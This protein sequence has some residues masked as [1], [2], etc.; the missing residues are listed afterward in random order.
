[1]RRELRILSLF[2][3]II[4]GLIV[5][6]AALTL[7]AGMEERIIPGVWLW[8]TSMG[9]AKLVDGNLGTAASV[10]EA[11]A[12]EQPRIVL[13]GPEEQRWAFSPVDL[14]VSVAFK[15][16][17]SKVY[18]VGHTQSEAKM[19]HLIPDV[20][21]DR[22]RVM[23]EGEIVAPVL[24][25]DRDQ[26][27]G[28]L[29]A[30]AAQL[31]YPP[32]DARLR[33][34]N[35][36]LLLDAGAP[37]RRLEITSTL[38][39]L[40]PLLQSP[41]SAVAPTELRLVVNGL[42]PRITDE[43]V[44]RAMDIARTIVSQELLL[45]L[46]DPEPGDPGPWSLARDV[47]ANMLVIQTSEANVSVGLDEEALRQFL[48][49]IAMALYREPVSSRFHF[50]EAT[51]ELEP[52]VSSVDGRALD[53]DATI[54]YVNDVL[55]VGQHVVPLSLTITPP[56]YPDTSTAQ[57]LDIQELVAM[58]ESYF[59]GSS[60]ARDKNIRL[61]ASQFDGLIIASGQTFSFNEYLGDVTPEKGYDESYVIIGN[62][63]VPGVGGG[64]CQ[65]ATTVFR[66]AFNGGYE[67][68]ER[69][70]HAYRVGYYEL[71][72]FGPG[73]DATVYSPLVDFRFVND[74]P[75]PLL[76]Q[77]E[78][79]TAHARLRFLFYSTDDGRTV[80]QIGPTW[81]DPIPPE[82]PVYEYDPTMPVGTVERLE[83]A[84]DGLTAVLERVVRDAEGHILHQDRFVSNFVPW[85][86]R[87][88]YGPEFIPPT[89]A[90]VLTPEVTPTPSTP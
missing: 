2:M 9:G 63:T 40:Y 14:G 35:H 45:I 34:G 62:R 84:H 44:A 31:D 78:V 13:V 16:T 28:K 33:M 23:L 59:S 77:T 65:V 55:Q 58:G 57:A 85:S 42:P 41:T 43:E 17:M 56:A 47:V 88:R 72:G 22:L 54:E 38:E 1:M 26:A 90:V 79:D 48:D 52:L 39:A 68:V 53:M 36:Q 5:G 89:D 24:V 67:I 64:I 12:L 81:G 70:P 20:L 49:P 83:R 69:W 71:G 76:I 60:S 8:H 27:I 66:A 19:R 46:P 37:G 29:R 51:L 87:Y 6:G 50:N 4:L 18:A 80:E 61:G 32:Q 21:E 11:L 3:A 10:T 73:F 86:A 7:G 75:Y 25:W 15:A 30:L 82:A 74:R